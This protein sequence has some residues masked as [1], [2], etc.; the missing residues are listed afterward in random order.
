LVEVLLVIVILGMLAMVVVFSVEGVTAD[1]QE[2][3]CGADAHTLST[4]A[5]SYFAQTGTRAI[6]GS[7]T[8]SDR[9]EQTLVDGG[10]LRG[11]SSWYDLDPAGNLIVTSDS[12][13]PV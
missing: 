4:A 13:C 3:S 12:P 10:F 7:G 1:A 8:G 11:V 6:A 5:E 9:F 2:T